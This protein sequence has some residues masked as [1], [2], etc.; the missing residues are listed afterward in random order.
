MKGTEKKR[1]KTGGTKIQ[2]EKEPN[3]KSE[4]EK[5]KTTSIREALLKC[6]HYRPPSS[7][8]TNTRETRRQRRTGV[9]ERI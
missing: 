3:I 8:S 9:D 4:R 6:C 7:A 2:R 1:E 5:D